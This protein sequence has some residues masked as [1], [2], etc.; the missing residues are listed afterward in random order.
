MKASLS[1][2]SNQIPGVQSDQWPGGIRFAHALRH[3]SMS[4]ELYAPQELDP[5][6]PHDQD[7]LYFIQSGS[8]DFF[9]AGTTE[10][11]QA[12]DCLFV[13][14][15]EEHRFLNFTIDFMTWVVFWGPKGGEQAA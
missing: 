6:K 15:G 3:G 4:V 1:Q 11:C 5:Q 10:K 12:G 7:E 9:L 13:Q 8:A 14:A 2:L